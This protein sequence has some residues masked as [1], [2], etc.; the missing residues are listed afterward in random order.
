M[1]GISTFNR[2]LL[3]LSANLTSEL[4]VIDSVGVRFATIPICSDPIL[5]VQIQFYTTPSI[6]ARGMGWDGHFIY[7]RSTLKEHIAS[8]NF[9]II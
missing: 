2:D 4:R 7:R 9:Y 8:N 1:C 3:F 6:Y 5:Y